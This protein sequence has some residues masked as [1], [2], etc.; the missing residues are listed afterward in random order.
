MVRCSRGLESVIR[1]SWT[2]RN[3]DRRFYGCPTLSPTYVNF[4]RWFDPPICQRSV[5]IIPG[6]LRSCN[7][8]KEILAMELRILANSTKL[9]DQ[10]LVY[11]DKQMQREAQLANELSNLMMQ[12]LESVNERP[13]RRGRNSTVWKS[14]RYG[15]SKYW[16]RRIG[17]FLEHGYAVSSLMDTAYWSPE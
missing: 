12:F 17:D 4:L 16:I 11:F 5:Q 3:H 7:E 14:V 9:P 2:N 1:T 15:V 6:L 13:I 10:L 8:L